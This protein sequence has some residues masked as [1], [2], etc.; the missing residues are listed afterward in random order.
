MVENQMKK[1]LT[2]VY[3]GWITWRWRLSFFGAIV[4]C[5]GA[6]ADLLFPS[7]DP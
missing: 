3:R 1:K 4:S 5:C 6:F 7:A 2:A